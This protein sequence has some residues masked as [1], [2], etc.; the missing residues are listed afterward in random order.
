[1][2]H[3]KKIFAL[4]TTIIAFVAFIIGCFWCINGF[5]PIFVFADED[6]DFYGNDFIAYPNDDTHQ[7][8]IIVKPFEKVN[9]DKVVLLLDFGDYDDYVKLPQNIPHK[10]VLYC[11]DADVLKSLKRSVWYSEG[12]DMCTISSRLLFYYNNRLIKSYNILL[13]QKQV[14]I[15]SFETG[16]IES[17]QKDGLIE[18]FSKFKPYKGLWFIPHR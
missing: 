10:K 16:W 5:S 4:V 17:V 9:F 13:E 12:G 7:D 8:S 2:V 14:G 1:M 11:S 6:R 3:Y 18:I 15:Q